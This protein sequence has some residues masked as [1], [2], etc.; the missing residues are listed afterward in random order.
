MWN[1]CS[2]LS[3][4]ILQLS[5]S[6]LVCTKP[7]GKES[8]TVSCWWEEAG[9]LEIWPALRQGHMVQPYSDDHSDILHFE[10]KV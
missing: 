2:W 7:R 3:S 9:G 1:I 5:L 10:A 4:A 6:E 8:G